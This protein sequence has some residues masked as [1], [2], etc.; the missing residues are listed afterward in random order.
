MF[1]GACCNHQIPAKIYEY[2]RSGRPIL[3]LV[4]PEGISANMLS[5]ARVKH[6]AN[7]ADAE[8]IAGTLRLFVKML[9][10]GVDFGVSRE[11]AMTHSRKARTKELAALLDGLART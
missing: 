6:I 10:E 7:I 5:E 1:Q 8:N 9:S 11:F 2:Y 4:G 3:G